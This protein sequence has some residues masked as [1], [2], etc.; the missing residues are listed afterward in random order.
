[1]QQYAE[2]AVVKQNGCKC[3]TISANS[4]AVIVSVCGGNMYTVVSQKNVKQTLTPA[5]M[6]VLLNLPVNMYQT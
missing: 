6:K 3:D 2:E 5:L 4:I 1:M